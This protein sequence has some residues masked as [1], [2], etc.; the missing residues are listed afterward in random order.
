M[1]TLHSLTHAEIETKMLWSDGADRL[2][3]VTAIWNP[4]E[5]PDAHVK[6]HNIATGQEYTCRLEAFLARFHERPV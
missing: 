2:F 4:H 5:E 3:R 6:Y 1:T